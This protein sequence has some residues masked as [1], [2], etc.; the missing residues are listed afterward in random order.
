MLYK[1]KVLLRSLCFWNAIFS[2]ISCAPLCG[3]FLSTNFT[4]FRHVISHHISLTRARKRNKKQRP[5]TSHYHFNR[6]SYGAVWSRVDCLAR[7]LS[8][9]LTHSCALFVCVDTRRPTRVTSLYYELPVSIVVCCSLES[10]QQQPIRRIAWLSSTRIASFRQTSSSENGLER[11]DT[12]RVF[13]RL[14]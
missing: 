10:P 4:C 2:V 1:G 5:V 7:L 14:R 12:W 6:Y 11:Y 13:S 8:I 3:I 9:D